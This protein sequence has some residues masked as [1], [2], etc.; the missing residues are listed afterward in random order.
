MII[1]PPLQAG[2]QVAIVAPAKKVIR[3]EMMAGISL[4]R[5]WGLLVK[6]GSHL[7]SSHHQYAGTDKERLE[8]LQNAIND[9]KIKAIMLARGGYGTTRI[10][11]RIDFS[12]IQQS[13]KWI[14]GFS[15]ITALLFQLHNLGIAAIHSSMP[16]LFKRAQSAESEERLR[17]LLFGEFIPIEIKNTPQNKPGIARGKIIGGNLSIICHLIGTSSDISFDH[18]I[19]L[20]EDVGEYL[21]N[22]DR[23]MI[24]LKRSSKLDNLA[25]LIVG[26]FSDVLDNDEPFGQTPFEIIREHIEDYNFP[27]AFGFPIGHSEINFP[28][29]VGVESELIV[30][31]Q[32]GA[33]LNCQL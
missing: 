31:Q 12:P 7:Y 5:T 4:M 29:P 30:D 8:D 25:G 19:L 16:M 20:L 33:K 24:Q 17:S 14:C 22:L 21:Y 23:M 6:E 28:L 2:D 18:K 32:I 10:I 13:P 9:E 3:Q 11:D 1:P 15:D 26:H 27:A